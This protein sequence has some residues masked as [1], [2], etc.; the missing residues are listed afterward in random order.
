MQVSGHIQGSVAPALQVID[1]NLNKVSN[2]T[3]P[4]VKSGAAAPVSAAYVE[5]SPSAQSTD[6]KE[7]AMEVSDRIEPPRGVPGFIKIKNLNRG[8]NPREYFDPKEL[9]DLTDSVR[10]HGINQPILV[11]PIRDGLYEI[12]AGE[13]RY[14]AALA[15]HGEEYDMPVL[16]RDC[17]D[18][19]ARILANIENTL[20]ADMSATEEA[21]SAAVIVGEVKGDRDEAAR[22]LSWS[23]SKL[24]SRL[25]LMN[26]SDSVRTMLNERKIKLGHAELFASLSKENQ[27]KI[28]P[29]LLERSLS[30][31]DL[32]ALIEKAAAKLATAI[33]DKADCTACQHNSSVQRTMFETSVTD[34]SC[35][36]STCYKTKTDAALENTKESLKDEYPVIRIVRAGDNFAQ[37]KL[38]ADGPA[39]VGEAQA[40][41]C[42]SCANFGA[43]VSA[44]PERL[45]AVFKDQCF[46]TA[47]NQE[48]VAARIRSETEAKDALAKAASE[49]GGSKDTPKG[50]TEANAKNPPVE[51]KTSVNE[52]DKVKAYREEIWRK[53][54]KKEVASSYDLSIQYL[55]A[56]A[57]TG[58]I[59]H[60]SQT[61]MTKVFEK[62]L[63]ENKAS[64]LQKV[65]DQAQQMSPD[66]MDNAMRMLA[67][68]AMDGIPVDELTR[69]T[70]HIKLDITKHWKMDATFLNLFT[71]SEIQVIA[72][73]VKL[74]KALGD[75]FNKLFAEKKDALIVALTSV[76][77]FDYS[78][79]IPPVLMYK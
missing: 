57:V 47:C 45:G 10:E 30:V 61:G 2:T 71:K 54:M 35:T 12:I 39:G 58:N 28:L 76:K 65:A 69:L 27:D 11:R 26:C 34:G 19:E 9:A 3:K 70:K 52:G 75:G 14:R 38:R 24:D 77:N 37:V 43:A 33:F 62:L 73:S 40:E 63:G 67:V 74:D 59:R 44:L 42:R 64:D 41:A 15:A 13:R 50:A 60:V 5:A 16:I 51:V 25:A 31:P 72:K 21:R 17:T 46:N 23:R 49:A 79:A 53:A 1:A 18:S 29:A 68:S 7:S 22:L 55:I 6:S 78:A 8:N 4:V 56:L 32:K 48:K 20:R 66:Q 36:N